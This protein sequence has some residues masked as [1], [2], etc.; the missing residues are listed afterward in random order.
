MLGFAKVNIQNG[1]IS[2][3]KTY[4]PIIVDDN[5]GL[6]LREIARKLN[7]GNLKHVD[8]VLNSI[9]NHSQCLEILEKEIP[10]LKAA[11]LSERAR[12]TVN[13]LEEALK[14]VD[15]YDYLM[16]EGD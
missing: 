8:I 7:L 6:E 9:F 5:T 13:G 3:L 10:L 11:N 15:V 1:S 2:V 4:S 14:D 12:I 16:F